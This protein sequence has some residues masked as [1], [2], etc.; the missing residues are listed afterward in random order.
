[1][2]EVIIFEDG[3]TEQYTGNQA[4]RSGKK[5]HTDSYTGHS[6]PNYFLMHILSYLETP[7]HL[8]QRLFPMHADLQKA[9]ALPSLDM[10]HHLR[11]HEWCQYRE[12]ITIE[13]QPANGSNGAAEEQ[14]KKRKKRKSHGEHA[15]PATLVDAGLSRPVAV[16]SPIPPQARVT[17][18]FPESAGPG[19]N[20]AEV[21]AEAIAPSAPREESGYY[22]GYSVRAANSLSA[23]IT[24][25]P[26]DGGY[27]LTFG[28]SERGV[29]VSTL[30]TSSDDEKIIPEY[31]HMLIAF[32]GVAGLESAVK[33]DSELQKLGATEPSGLF[34]YWINLCPGQGSRTIRTE[35]AVWLGLMS[36]REV[37]VT[38]GRKTP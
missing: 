37:A 34:D 10:P 20:D 2:D 14:G 11:P 19:D 25:C 5:T 15:Y 9:G 35:E 36:L 16:A 17:L 32:G 29:P 4:R 26:F 33:C 24:E 13:Q 27:D 21:T 12:G 3:Q 18:K 6:D 8:R 1:M 38:K 23:V 30:N 28:T 7:P 31:S 22:W